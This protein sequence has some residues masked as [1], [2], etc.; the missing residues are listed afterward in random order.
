MFLLN[1]QLQ[2]TKTVSVACDD[3]GILRFLLHGITRIFVGVFFNPN[4]NSFFK[5]ISELFKRMSQMK[6]CEWFIRFAIFINGG[7]NV[8]C[9]INWG[10]KMMTKAKLLI[11]A[12]KGTKRMTKINIEMEFSVVKS[13]IQL[14]LISVDFT[15]FKWQED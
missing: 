8:N 5:K 1:G 10:V 9:E 11:Y 3:V 6:R 2:H 14:I 4:L 15:T 7:G 12:T 13:T